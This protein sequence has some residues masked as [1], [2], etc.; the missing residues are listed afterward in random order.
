MS[1]AKYSPLVKYPVRTVLMAPCLCGATMYYA[2]IS[3]FG[4][5]IVDWEIPYDKRIKS[6]HRFDICDTHGPM[7]ITVPVSRPADNGKRLLWND[8][9][10]SGH[11]AWWNTLKVTLESAYGR[12]PFFE[13]YR[14]RLLP[15]LGEDTVG[16]PLHVT[17]MKLHAEI[18]SIL[19]ITTDGSNQ[20]IDGDTCVDFRKTFPQSQDATEYWQVRSDRFGFI[21]DLSILD[22]I[23]NLGPEAPLTLRKM[24]EHI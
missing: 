12:T 16:T 15:L 24:S 6:T 20:I 19:G 5:A 18:C 10:I 4:K 17:A 1:P 9:I 3:A 8:M 11:G 13:Y 2:A 23:F 21:P 22:M 14:D 7:S